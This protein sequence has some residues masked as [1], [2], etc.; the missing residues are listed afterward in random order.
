MREPAEPF[1][2]ADI[3]I[4]PNHVADEHM[5]A[6]DVIRGIVGV[7]RM[8][9]ALYLVPLDR[10]SRRASWWEWHITLAPR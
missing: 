8:F 7:V 9:G 6:T 2:V 10:D 1:L 3:V 4:V 5:S